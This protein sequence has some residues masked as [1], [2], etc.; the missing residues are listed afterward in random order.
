M[1]G[2]FDEATLRAAWD[3]ARL[4]EC[5]P[6]AAVWALETPDAKA[7]AAAL[8]TDAFLAERSTAAGR[9]SRRRRA[10]GSSANRARR[11]SGA[12]EA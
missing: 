8:V 11:P 5:G 10:R 3:L 2:A 1:G 7:A 4:V 9:P 6:R 12:Y